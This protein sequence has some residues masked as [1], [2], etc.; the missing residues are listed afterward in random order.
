VLVGD[1]EQMTSLRLVASPYNVNAVALAC[2]PEAIADQAYV[3]QYVSEIRE[4]RARLQSILEGAGIQFW[5]SQANFVL[6]RV[7]PSKM[8]AAS[9]VDSM[10][11]RGILVRDRSSDYGC[12]GCVRI[13]AGTKQQSDRLFSALQESFE[14]LGIAQGAS[15][16]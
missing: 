15:R 14:E 16:P 12:E 5:P 11:R 4:E 8:Q 7:G 9:F 6:M 2:L 3:S 10:R 13:T 1:A